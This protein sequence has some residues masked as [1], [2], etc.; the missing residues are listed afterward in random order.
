MKLAPLPESINP[1]RLARSGAEITGH[2]AVSSLPRL[3]A[4]VVEDQRH[5]DTWDL[6]VVSI[7]FTATQDEQFR[8][9]LHGELNSQLSVRCQLCLSPMQITIS[10]QFNWLVVTTEDQA[11]QALPHHDPV[12]ADEDRVNL[13]RLI[14]DEVL[15]E[16][17]I[18]P[19]HKIT[20]GCLTHKSFNP[21]NDNKHDS[22]FNRTSATKTTR[23]FADLKSLFTE[24][25][26]AT[27]LFDQHFQET[28]H[29]SSKK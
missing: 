27:D 20:E 14:E 13:L 3:A 9:H 10:D 22:K 5:K 21:V 25:E 24:K 28:P 2:I 6:G 15:L 26:Q 8:I 19:S 16:L 18:A 7:V 1:W 4:L 29:G 17:P 12:F 23:P 11:D